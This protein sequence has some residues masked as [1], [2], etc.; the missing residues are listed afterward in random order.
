MT[1]AT[2]QKRRQ[3]DTIL[4]MMSHRIDD[5]EDASRSTSATLQQHMTECAA[6]QKKVLGVVI[7]LSGWTVAHSPEAGK[8]MLKIAGF[9]GL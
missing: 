4:G 9:V 7:F 8:L 1:S 6:I 2:T 5:I 3:D